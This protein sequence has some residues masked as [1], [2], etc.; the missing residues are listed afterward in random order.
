MERQS[1][2]HQWR[3]KRA[4]RKHRGGDHAEHADQS[5]ADAEGFLDAGHQRRQSGNRG[6]E[7]KSRQ[8]YCNECD[9]PVI[10]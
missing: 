1:A 2:Q 4:E 3:A 10:A 8:K 6:A 5:A 9:K 7:V